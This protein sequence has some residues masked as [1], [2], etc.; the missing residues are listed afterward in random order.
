LDSKNNNLAYRIFFSEGT[1]AKKLFVRYSLTTLQITIQ[2]FVGFH[3]QVSFTTPSNTWY[4]RSPIPFW[5]Y[6]RN[7]GQ[8]TR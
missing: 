4:A 2:F 3:F 7:P 5:G 6:E 8:R 1:K